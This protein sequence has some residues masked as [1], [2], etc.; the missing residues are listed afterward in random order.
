MYRVNDADHVSWDEAHFGKF[1][2]WYI[3]GTF[4]FDVHPPLGKM[5][6]AGMGALT[7]YNGSFHFTEPGNKYG[8]HKVREWL[9]PSIIADCD[10]TI[11]RF[12]GC[13]CCARC[14]GSASSHLAS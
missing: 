1:A 4:F 2:S 8:D 11:I 13:V 10:P 9:T 3:N 7:G 14:S 12:T 5:M 6:I